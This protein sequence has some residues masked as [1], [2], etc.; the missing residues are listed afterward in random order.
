[1]STRKP[2]KLARAVLATLTL[3]AACSAPIVVDPNEPP[4]TVIVHLFNKDTGVLGEPIHVLAPEEGLPCC[5]IEPGDSRQVSL[6][7]QH[8]ALF[9]FLA[10]RSGTEQGRITCQWKGGSSPNVA[11]DGSKLTC[12]GWF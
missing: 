9:Q 1:M 4:T 11:W 12:T 8:N 7:M 10:V 2:R 3:L 5:R 6:S